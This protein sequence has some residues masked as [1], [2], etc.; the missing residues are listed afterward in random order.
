[1][2][3]VRVAQNSF[4]YG[5]ASASLTMRTDSPVYAGSAQSLQNMVVMAE[6]GVKK[7]Y[8]MK[9]IYDYSLTYNSSYPEQSHL[10][11]FIF[12]NNEEYIISVEH[13]KIRCFR[14]VDAT[15][16][17]LV[18]TVTTDTGGNSL[19]FDRDYLQEYTF[20][21]SG[22]V[23]WICH[24]LFMPRLIVRTSLTAFEVQT[25]SFD[26]RQDNKKTF[27]PYSSFHSAGV[28]LGVSGFSGSITVTTSASYFTSAHVGSRIRKQGNEILITA[29]SSGTQATGT[30]IDS[31][32][33]NLSV[34][35]PIRTRE[36][37]AV[38]EMTHINHGFGGNETI[39]I[40]HA[41]AT[42]GIS[43]T[44]FQ[45]S[46][47]V[48]SIID[49]NTYTF[50]AGANATSSEDGGGR[51]VIRAASATSEWDEQS[52]SAARGYPAAVT[53]H[54]NRLVFG[55]TIAE[56]DTI[57]MSKIGEYFNH[58]VDE[59][60]D[61]DAI[62]LTAATGRTN[63]IRYLVSNRDL[64]VFTN[65]AE[66]YVPTYLNQ[67]TTPTNAQI[68][69][70]T[71]YGTSFVTP[72]S[73]DGATIFA[74]SNGRIIREYIYTDSEDAYTSVPV[75]TIASDIFESPPKYLAVSHSTFGLPDSYAAMTLTNGDLAVFSSNRVEKRAAWTTFTTNGLFSSVVAIEDRIFVN[76]YDSE[77]KLQLCELRENI[78]LDFYNYVS[79]SS[80]LAT[81]SPLYTHNDVID[82]LGF[83]GTNIDSLGSFTVNSSNKI[84]LS[85]HA[86]YTHVYVGK[87][88]DSKIITNPVDA[89]LGAGPATGETRGITNIVVDFKDTRSAK[90]NNKPFIVEESFTGKR[91]FRSLGYERNPQITIEQNDPL[92]MQVNGLVAELIV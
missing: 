7:R 3:K 85:N 63:E 52:F 37:S 83:D 40:D 6:G 15:T 25:Y 10:M 9:H 56:P 44:N 80:G 42:G 50:N 60:A 51:V 82:V 46:R 31:L 70:Q 91:E 4:Q 22:D 19:P 55:G 28:T 87:K 39:Q 75:S 49:E 92:P 69:Q 78:G 14:V 86:G 33:I 38:C 90:V 89:T 30:I 76:A 61:T 27:Q 20:A 26:V 47:T 24:P 65:T 13:Q 34:L 59:G 48:Q 2:Q 8:G 43:S 45:G 16:V 74:Q 21:Q 5:E 81:V 29:V 64:Q 11:P 62:V 18:A 73:V 88:F 36:G 77:N 71:P 41:A 23:M 58:D 1:M 57:F 79:V 84:D 68:R 12:D 66:L 72:V 17:T 35:N 53:F 54:E 32:T 67:A